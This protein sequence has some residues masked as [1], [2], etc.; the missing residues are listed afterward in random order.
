MKFKTR[1]MIAFCLIAIL[2]IILFAG[3][4]TTFLIPQWKNMI[5]GYQLDNSYD[6]FA[7]ASLRIAEMLADQAKTGVLEAEN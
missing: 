2:P 6:G 7:G 1:L 5:K 3:I 4:G